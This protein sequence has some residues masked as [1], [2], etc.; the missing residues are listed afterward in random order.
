[1]LDIEYVMFLNDGNSYQKLRFILS[2]SPR[3][4]LHNS[5]SPE[6][7]IRTRN[8]FHK[9][10]DQPQ[11]STARVPQGLRPVKEPNVKGRSTIY[12]HLQNQK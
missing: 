7:N 10:A 2:S 8:T 3:S 5:T 6:L 9:N 4:L 1:M 11:V 12:S